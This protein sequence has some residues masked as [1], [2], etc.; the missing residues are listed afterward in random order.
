LG[1]ATLDGDDLGAVLTIEGAVSVDLSGLVITDGASEVGGAGG[2]DNPG[3]GTVTLVDS[4]VRGNFGLFAGGGIY[5]GGTMDVANSTVANNGV[6]GVSSLA[7]GIFN[8]GTLTVQRSTVTQNVSQGTGGGV[9]NW[10]GTLTITASELSHNRSWFGGGLVN[11]AGGT[12]SV[13]DTRILENIASQGGLDGDGGGI[14][15]ESALTITNSTVSGTGR[16]PAAAS[17]TVV[18]RRS[19]TRRSARTRRARSAEAFTTS[20]PAS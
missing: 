20:A 7:G 19:S 1:V 16:E 12:A 17:S 3:P 8:T 9:V 10:G 11:L 18:S 5:N 14:L 15:N 4:T 6:L 13:E 2:I